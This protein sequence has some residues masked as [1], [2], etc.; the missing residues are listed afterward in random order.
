MHT[1]SF[2]NW[3]IPKTKKKRGEKCPLLNNL[4]TQSHLGSKLLPQDNSFM[5][6]TPEMAFSMS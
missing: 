2:F 6:I 1:D 5:N 3:K 4:T